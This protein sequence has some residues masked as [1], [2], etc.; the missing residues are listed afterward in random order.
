MYFSLLHP[1]P[2]REREAVM[3]RLAQAPDDDH[4]WT[5]TL[6]GGTPEQRRDFIFR[7]YDDARQPL[8]YYLVSERAPVS[9]GDAWTLQT[10][11]YAPQ[12]VV[13]DRLSFEA[14]VCPSVRHGHSGKSSRHDVVIDAKKKLLAAR[15]LSRWA[16]WQGSDKPLLQDLV[17][18]R[19]LHWLTQRATPHGFELDAQSFTVLS[20]EPG[21]SQRGRSSDELRQHS[22]VELRGELTVRDTQAF[23]QLL[24]KGLGS[25]KAF[26]C[27]LMLVRR[28]I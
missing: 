22:A 21:L 11:P 18:E 5:W 25:A 27:G 8:R 14:R 26:G 23:T 2:G 19:C 24:L 4:R 1:T 12:L 13:G 16:D 6:F 17:H 10:R 7:R 28:S 15:G 3:Q 20:Y 9:P